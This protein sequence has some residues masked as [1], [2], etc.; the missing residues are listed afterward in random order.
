MIAVVSV[1][2]MSLTDT[3]MSFALWLSIFTL[4]F[5]EP[6]LMS[7]TMLFVSGT[8]VFNIASTWFATAR[9]SSEFVLWISTS[10]GLM[11]TPRESSNDQVADGSSP[12][13]GRTI[14]LISSTPIVCSVIS[15]S[16]M[17]SDPSLFPLTV[18]IMSVH[19]SRGSASMTFCWRSKRY[20]VVMSSFVPGSSSKLI[21]TS[22]SVVFLGMKSNPSFPNCCML[23]I[24]RST[25]SMIRR[26]L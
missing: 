6:L 22:S 15:G 25:R 18:I 20:L 1:L 14:F 16:S 4:N 19:A 8:C 2:V 26:N 24:K 11:P 10:I 9:A 12:K 3:P 13:S 17:L 23:N 21:A 7:L 5:G